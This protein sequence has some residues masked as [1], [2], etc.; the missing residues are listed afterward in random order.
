MT[1]QAQLKGAPWLRDLLVYNTRA[2]RLEAAGSVALGRSPTQ[3]MG[4]WA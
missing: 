1:L 3:T 4:V 2:A